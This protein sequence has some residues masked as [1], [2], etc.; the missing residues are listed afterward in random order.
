MERIM[1]KLPES[2]SSGASLL[3]GFFIL[4]FGGYLML[5]PSTSA[6]KTPIRDQLQAIQVEDLAT[7][8]SYTS[9]EFQKNTSLESFKH[10]VNSY[11]GLR[12]NESVKFDDRKIKDGIGMVKATL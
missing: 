3:V 9:K 12:N 11:S 6:L 7:A 1:S 8:Y 2:L 10:F 4:I 5:S